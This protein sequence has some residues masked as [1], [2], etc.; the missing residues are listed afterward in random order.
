MATA[1]VT[2]ASAGIGLEFAR[3][4]ASEK[5]DLV[6]VAR[7]KSR[8][9]EVAKELR[10]NFGVQVEIIAADL[11]NHDDLARVANR[12]SLVEP[13]TPADPP[14]FGLARGETQKPVSILVNNAGFGTGQA[15]VGGDIAKEL[16]VIDVLITAVLVLSKAAAQ[17][18]VKRGK[19]AIINVGSIAAL[20]A[21]GTYAAAKAWVRTFTEGLAA[22]LKGTGVTATVIAPGLTRSEFHQRAGIKADLFPDWTWLDASHV[23][24]EGLAAAKRGAVHSTPSLRYK[25]AAAAL[26]VAPRAVVGAIGKP[27]GL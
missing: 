10:A 16:A 17:Q 19:G 5:H 9:A 1:L 18:M 4:L 15:F 24:R 2:G 27:P 6:L 8:L 13:E 26:R 20:T 7:N 23:V 22:E 21:G 3:Q 25:A 11:A 14:A 12:L